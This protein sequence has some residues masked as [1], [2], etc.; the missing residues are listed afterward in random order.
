MVGVGVVCVCGVW[1]VGERCFVCVLGVKSGYPTV[2][3]FGVFW[4]VFGAFGRRFEGIPWFF[5]KGWWFDGGEIW[6]I[7]WISDEYGVGGGA[8]MASGV[9][10]CSGG[11]R[12]DCD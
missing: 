12:G 4:S 7:V 3:C 9:L 6:E 8:R 1:W 10:G 2:M 11:C 5:A